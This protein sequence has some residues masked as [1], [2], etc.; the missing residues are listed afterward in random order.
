[1][2]LTYANNVFLFSCSYDERETP[3]EAGFAW[4]GGQWWTDQTEIARR[5]EGHADAAAMKAIQAPPEAPIPILTPD[6]E[7]TGEHVADIRLVNGRSTATNRP[8][9]LIEVHYPEKD[10]ELRSVV[11][12]IGFRWSGDKCWK[13]CLGPCQGDPIDRVAE[14]AHL[15]LEAGFRVRIRHDLA[16][17]RAIS[18]AF[19]PEQTRWVGFYKAMEGDKLPAGDWLALAWNQVMDD[20]YNVAKSLPGARYHR[21]SVM[22]PCGAYE[23]VGD[24]ATKHGFETT[25]AALAAVE[26][27]RAQVLA[28]VVV[29]PRKRREAEAPEIRRRPAHIAIPAD[30]E[31]VDASLLD[32]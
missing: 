13:R 28:A 9:Q 6:A 27:Q 24:F 23:A 22:V 16:R 26:R 25:P 8:C 19:E 10:E 21:G 7:V 1:M 3:K 4:G 20:F 15:L 29:K 30:Q 11:K 14:T 5:L 17:E 18:G 31:G 2:K 12:D 32:D